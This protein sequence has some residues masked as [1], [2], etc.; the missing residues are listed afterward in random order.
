MEF[1]WFAFGAAPLGNMNRILAETEADDVIAAAWDAGA[2]YFDTAPLYGHGLSEMR[3]GRM[4]AL[5]P[6]EQFLLSTKVGR[7]L[8]PCAAGEEASG[9]YLSTPQVRVRYD[10][11]RDGI[12]RSFEESL[13][14]LGGIS[15][16]ILFVHDLD[17][18]T[19]GTE[20]EHHW[21]Q[22]MCRGGWEAL[23]E[24]RATGAV[25]AI[26][27]GMNENAPCERLVAE[28]DPDLLLLAGRYT[29]LDQTA[30]VDLLPACLSRGVGVVIGGPF[31]S[32]ILATGP[33][34]DA[35]YAYSP[36]P[37]DIIERVRVMAATCAR[38]GIPL[39]TAALHFARSH[40]AIVSIIPGGQSVQEVT[41]N[42]QALA[43]A[44]P[45][46]LWRELGVPAGANAIC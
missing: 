2:R 31:N 12:M 3:L 35:R 25:R 15:P 26:G 27:A 39:A 30:A 14:R 13:A 22:L 8:E 29:L 4:L 1:S 23:R 44:V 9:I 24:L 20:Y 43:D 16:D 33:V 34:P 32:G 11:S 10:Y 37:P 41:R 19:H 45:E 46:D 40:P 42:A 36:A 18:V 28:A 21:H 38:Y 5:K 17:P 7:I 6:R